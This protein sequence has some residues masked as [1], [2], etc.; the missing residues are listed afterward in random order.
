MTEAAAPRTL[1][2]A[3]RSFWVVAAG[4]GEVRAAPPLE[5]GPGQVLVRALFSAVSRGTESL[6]FSG[7]VPESEFQRMRGPG[8]G[9]AFPFPVKYGYA[10]VGVG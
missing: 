6:V 9:G 8:M 1:P 2:T 4:R 3:A 5:P 10:A 7:K